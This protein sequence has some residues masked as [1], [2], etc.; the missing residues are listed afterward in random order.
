MDFFFSSP[1][2]GQHIVLLGDSTF[3][4]K[5]YVDEGG[6]SVVE[7]LQTLAPKATLLAKDGGLIHAINSQADGIPADA[8]HVV[9][10][11]GGNNGLEAT[12]VLLRECQ[13]VEEGVILLQERMV[14]LEKEYREVM[15]ALVERCK[16]KH[17]V[18]L[19]S[20]YKPCFEHFDVRPRQKAVDVGVVLFADCIH[21]IARDL[22]VP[23]L[24]MRSIMDTVDCF[25]NPIE[26][27]AIGGGKIAK[28]IVDL[29]EKHD[30]DKGICI[31]YP[32]GR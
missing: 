27:S 10:S 32:Q 7:H 15:T 3:D 1:K 29:V 6:K 4:N 16:G 9:V 5:N 8:S 22:G 31:V 26:P 13:T 11:I 21:R 24:D 28:G 30:F 23:V 19:C 14:G 25:A 2:K 12:A 18:V 17:H 20:V